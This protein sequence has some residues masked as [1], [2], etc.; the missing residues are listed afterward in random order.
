MGRTWFLIL[1]WIAKFW[2]SFPEGLRS[3]FPGLRVANITPGVALFL[4][5]AATVL[6][7]MVHN[8][9]RNARLVAA[10]G[11]NVQGLIALDKLTILDVA[12]MVVGFSTAAT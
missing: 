7:D 9:L 6:S 5:E 1:F 4:E 3:L 8:G 12:G 10:L 11:S 2:S